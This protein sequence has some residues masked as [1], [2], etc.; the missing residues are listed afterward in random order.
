MLRASNTP[1]RSV[2][3]VR[4]PTEHRRAPPPVNVMGGRG[5]ESVTGSMGM[6]LSKLQIAER[7]EPSV[8]QSI[9]SRRVVHSEQPPQRV[10]Y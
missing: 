2:K 6:N 4:K 8:L 3:V 9:G 10:S 1:F 5:F 7:G